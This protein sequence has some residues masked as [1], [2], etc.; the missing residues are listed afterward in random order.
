MQSHYLFYLSSSSVIVILKFLKLKH[1]TPS[2]Q[3]GSRQKTQ[4]L[5]ANQSAA[6]RYQLG[7]NSPFQ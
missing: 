7:V 2:Y 4:V 1:P 6:Y 3:Q 5:D